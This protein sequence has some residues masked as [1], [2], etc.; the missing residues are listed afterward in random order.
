MHGDT[1]RSSAS[2]PA[3]AR[4]PSQY[5]A[6][7]SFL[8][9]RGLPSLSASAWHAHDDVWQHS[10]FMMMHTIHTARKGGAAPRATAQHGTGGKAQRD[11]MGSHRRRHGAYGGGAQQPRVV[12]TQRWWPHRA[13]QYATNDIVPLCPHRHTQ[14]QRRGSAVCRC[15]PPS[16]CPAPGRRTTQWVVTVWAAMPQRVLGDHV[17][18]SRTHTRTAR[19]VGGTPGTRGAAPPAGS[20]RTTCLSPPYRMMWCGFPH[21][22]TALA[23]SLYH[24]SASLPTRHTLGCPTTRTED[25]EAERR[26]PGGYVVGEH[27]ER[28]AQQRVHRAHTRT[29]RWCRG[30][31]KHRYCTVIRIECIVVQQR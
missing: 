6:S 28:G 26:E 5:A 14:Q 27:G 31:E 11:M 30:T 29:P 16:S 12:C 8:C 18:T 22:C 21:Y 2:S 7:F 4:H 10:T 17:R 20:L 3:S 23:L 13:Q 19:H 9:A 1:R 15:A 25:T 24:Y